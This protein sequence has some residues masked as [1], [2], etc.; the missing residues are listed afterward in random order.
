MY[1]G[2]AGGEAGCC[3]Q[4]VSTLPDAAAR[5]EEVRRAA[6]AI[7]SRVSYLASPYMPCHAL[8]RRCLADLTGMLAGPDAGERRGCSCGGRRSRC[9]QQELDG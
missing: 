7:L 1:R 6:D 9:R 8:A 4:D 3:V 5:F 2:R